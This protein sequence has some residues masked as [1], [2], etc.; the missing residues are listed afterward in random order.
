MKNV[1]K[2]LAVVA[3]LAAL[4]TACG[5]ATESAPSSDKAEAN[6]STSRPLSNDSAPTSEPTPEPDPEPSAEPFGSTW[7]WVDGLE[8]SVTKP[9]PF[10]PSTWAS[11]GESYDSHVKFDVTITNGTG[12]AFDPSMALVYASGAGVEGEEVFDSEGGLDGSPMTRVLP[13]QS[14]TWTVGFGIGGS[15]DLVIQVEPDFEHEAAIFT[16]AQS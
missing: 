5:S 15:N 1:S 13:G 12:Q 6:H 8:V 9:T 7:A 11:G 4:T 16:A 2:G 14:V 3:V 10:T